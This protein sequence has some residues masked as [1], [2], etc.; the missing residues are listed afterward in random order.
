MTQTETKVKASTS[1]WL[2]IARYAVTAALGGLTAAYSYYP[3][4]TWIPIVIGMVGTIGIHVVP[5]SAGN[6]SPAG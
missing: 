5:S 6:K 4:V 1:M 3:H 2:T